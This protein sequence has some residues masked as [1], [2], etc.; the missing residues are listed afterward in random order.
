[1]N[2]DLDHICVCVCTYKRPLLLRR[3]LEKLA[4][5]RTGGRFTYS[6]VVIDNDAERSAEMVIRAFSKICSLA[7]TYS[8]EERRGIALARNRAVEQC[9][10]S[11]IAFIDDD[12]FPADTWLITLYALCSSRLVAGVLG[13]VKCH[14]DE[15]PPEWIRKGRFYERPMRPTGAVVKWSEARTGNALLR[16]TTLSGEVHP[17]RPEFRSGE[18]QDF[19]RRMIEKGHVFIWSSEA[20]VF[21]VV[22]PTRWRRSFLLRRALLR[23]A[24]NRLHPTFGVWSMAKSIVAVV[25]YSAA[26]P[27]ALFLGH[28]KVMILLV[29]TCD[30]LG[31]VLAFAGIQAMSDPYVT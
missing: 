3:L 18:D 16:A 29:K 28:D 14:F 21:E 2:G 31:K 11:Y 23:G 10:G 9:S 5:Q 30:H 17:F 20:V 24:M 27:F 12:E 4:V 7:V 8:V 19:F 25:L 22:P 6:V 13:P 15:Q 1:M 26:L